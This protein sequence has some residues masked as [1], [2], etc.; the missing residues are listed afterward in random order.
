MKCYH[1]YRITTADRGKESAIVT[2][3]KIVQSLPDS[4]IS[5]NDNRNPH[6]FLKIS[7]DLGA[8]P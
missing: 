2:P 6:N 5:A 3:G 7:I 8:T 1:N 4:H